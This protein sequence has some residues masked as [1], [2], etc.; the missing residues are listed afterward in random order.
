MSSRFASQSMLNKPPPVCQKHE[1]GPTLP[2][3]TIWPSLKAFITIYNP[4]TE[5]SEIWTQEV[6]IQRPGATPE[7]F[8]EKIDS[9]NLLWEVR[10][11]LRPDYQLLFMDVFLRNAV[12]TIVGQIFPRRP[13]DGSFPV[14]TGLQELQD[15]LAASRITARIIV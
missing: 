7:Y 12:P 4:V 14:D 6:N 13:L 1:A 11:D 15:V 2:P 10:V 9:R 3:D 5:P 8:G